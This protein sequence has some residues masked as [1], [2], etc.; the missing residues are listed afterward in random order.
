MA[1]A[2]DAHPLKVAT[3]TVRRNLNGGL[4]GRWFMGGFRDWDVEVDRLG[5]VADGS[6]H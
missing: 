1:S 6:H 4:F 2:K 3:R 5:A